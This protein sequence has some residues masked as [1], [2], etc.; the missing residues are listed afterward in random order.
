M[1]RKIDF[2]NVRPAFMKTQLSDEE[3]SSNSSEFMTF[4]FTSFP[5]RQNLSAKI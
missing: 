4:Q 3:S 1:S 2:A 5:A